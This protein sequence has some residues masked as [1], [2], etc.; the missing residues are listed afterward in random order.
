[1]TSLDSVLV[2]GA[3]FSG[4]KHAKQLIVPQLACEKAAQYRAVGNAVL[5]QPAVQDYKLTNGHS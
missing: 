4:L 5:F 2:E 1:V 3:F